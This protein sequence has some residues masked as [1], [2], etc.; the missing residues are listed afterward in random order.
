MELCVA[1]DS[2]STAGEMNGFLKT[3]VQLLSPAL[4]CEGPTVILDGIKRKVDLGVVACH[5]SD[6]VGAWSELN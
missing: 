5:S 2:V 1:L 3:P 4:K 6:R